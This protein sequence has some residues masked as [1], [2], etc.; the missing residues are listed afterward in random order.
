MVIIA[1][2]PRRHG[3][4]TQHTLTLSGVSSRSMLLL[5]IQSCCLFCPQL[6]H[7]LKRPLPS[8]GV[9]VSPKME[10]INFPS[11]PSLLS[12]L[13]FVFQAIIIPLSSL[14]WFQSLSVSSEAGEPKRDPDGFEA[15][16]VCVLKAVY[17]PKC[18]GSDGR[19]GQL[20][21]GHPL[22]QIQ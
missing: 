17:I 4:H 13:A 6:G 9:Q 22:T 8:S 5:N 21:R 10:T 2:L 11:H 19:S 12:R 14:I 15:T 7:H 1:P 3:D 16:I 18:C 20:N